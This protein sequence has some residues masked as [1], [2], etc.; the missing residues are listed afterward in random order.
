MYTC[1]S[2][3]NKCIFI[4][5]TG[6]NYHASNQHTNHQHWKVYRSLLPTASSFIRTNGIFLCLRAINFMRTSRFV[7]FL[8]YMYRP[9]AYWAL[10]VPFV[11]S[12][13]TIIAYLP[14]LNNSFP[15]IQLNIQTYLSSYWHT[16]TFLWLWNLSNNYGTHLFNECQM[17]SSREKLSCLYSPSKAEV[18]ILTEMAFAKG[19]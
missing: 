11:F 5:I 3:W 2:W 19:W 4:H 18:K 10:T 6:C 16:L 1:I 12:Y 13:I 8:V 9:V 14:A 7:Y 15:F 17:S